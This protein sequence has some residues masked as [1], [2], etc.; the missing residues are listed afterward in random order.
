MNCPKCGSPVNK[1][2]EYCG[3]CGCRL[4][5]NEGASGGQ[6]LHKKKFGIL[7]LVVILEIVAIAFIAVMVLRGFPDKKTDD[8]KPVANHS[9]GETKSE[10]EIL[11]DE[12]DADGEILK[13]ATEDNL[14]SAKGAEN[15][16][17]PEAHLIDNA[18][19]L[20]EVKAFYKRI[21]KNQVINSFASST[22]DQDLVD[23]F[24]FYVL[25]GDDTTNWQE[26]VSGPGVDEYLSFTFDKVYS[27]EYMTFKLGNWK[28]DEYYNGNYRP[29]TLLITSGN[30]SWTITFA[31]VK[32]EF[33]VRLDPAVDMNNIRI[34]IKDVYSDYMQWEDT[35]ITDVGLWYK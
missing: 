9:S 2:N 35:P 5:N 18:D 4:M 25:D 31:D 28:T 13:S 34:T 14:D 7:I 29:K 24:S 6:K 21:G 27:V 26:G 22:I 30:N 19:T 10:N 33:L 20:K 16:Q 15:S 23:N 8:D 1:N 12:T 11:E 17:E 3:S 32:Q